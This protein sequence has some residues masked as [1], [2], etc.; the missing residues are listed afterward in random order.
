M[1]SCIM[2]TPTENMR[3]TTARPPEA[4]RWQAERLKL[5]VVSMRQACRRVFRFET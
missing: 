1:P 3:T 2:T 4:C 5:T